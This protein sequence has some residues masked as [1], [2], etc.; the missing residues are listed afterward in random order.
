MSSDSSP[1]P[2]PQQDSLPYYEEGVVAGFPSPVMGELNGT[3][4]LNTLCIRHPA[5]TYYVRARGDSMIG[6]GINDGDI[7]VVDRSI[8]PQHG[9]IIIA[10]IDGEFTVKRLLK[11]GNKVFLAPEN[12]AYQ[13]R[14]LTE[15]EQSEFFGVVTWI[16]KST[17]RRNSGKINY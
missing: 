2:E 16:L 10:A 6:A 15:A 17:N 11:K 12:P 14:L 1:A 4:N 9:D 8:E 7:L 5:T 13:S 3:L